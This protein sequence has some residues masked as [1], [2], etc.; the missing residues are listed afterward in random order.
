MA[1]CHPAGW[2][3]VP[4]QRRIFRP[5]EGDG[6][7]IPG[8]SARSTPIIRKKADMINDTA[9]VHA[10]PIMKTITM[11]SGLIPSMLDPMMRSTMNM[12]Q[13]RAT[14]LLMPLTRAARDAMAT[15][16]IPVIQLWPPTKEPIRMARM[17]V[18]SAYA[19]SSHCWRRV[20]L[21]AVPLKAS[22]PSEASIPKPG[23]LIVIP[24]ATGIAM[25]R[26]ALIIWDRGTC[27]SRDQCDTSAR[28][29]RTAA[30]ACL[31][32][33]ILTYVHRRNLNNF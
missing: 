6:G 13:D 16:A 31:F 12:P 14:V 17:P 20:P 10:A 18:T 23:W 32:T 1:Y 22:P 9:R 26:A 2:F 5:I 19:N 15:I 7:C 8:E 24:A 25:P 29:D 11:M 27:V 33:L 21:P 4:S 3:N 30:A 28:T